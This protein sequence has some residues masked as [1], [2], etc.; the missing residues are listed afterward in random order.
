MML[1]ETDKATGDA[2]DVLAFAEYERAVI[3]HLLN[4]S[5][6]AFPDLSQL[7]PEDFTQRLTISAWIE[8]A[9]LRT[10]GHPIDYLSL[11]ER[12]VNA[13]GDRNEVETFL[14]DC[15]LKAPTAQH[16]VYHVQRIQAATRHR[17]VKTA[18]TVAQEEQGSGAKPLSDI[19]RT[20][21]DKL[22]SIEAEEVNKP[23]IISAA[24]FAAVNRTEPIQ[25]VHGV[26]RA[27][28]VGILSASSKAGKTWALLG[29][30]FAVATS[31]RWLGW[32]TAQGRVLYINAELPDYDLESRLNKL[33]D[34]LGLGGIPDG[35][36]VWHLRG[37]TMTIPQLLPAI[38]RRQRNHG[39]YA[40]IMPDPLYRFGQGRD[41]ND[42]AVQALTMGEL[43]ELAEKTA[44]AVLAAHHFSKGNQSGREHID[45]GS[46]AGMF[47]RAPDL[48][49]TLTAHKEP[50]CY[51]LESTCRSFAKPDPVVVR[52]NYPS[53]TVA[54]ELDPEE[55]KQPTGRPARYSTDELLDLLPADGL[56]HGDW[57]DKAKQETG[58]GATRFNE[59]V[60]MAKGSGQVVLACG[61]YIRGVRYDPKS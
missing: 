60:R 8:A 22:D 23:Q 16:A 20:L 24:I 1:R 43:G 7:Q 52:W 39:P 15:Q 28:Q 57:K 6:A 3:G 51:T 44:A 26:L 35:L 49:A 42:N 40:L 54:E 58:I 53:W 9:G 32:N 61:K 33:A 27:G 18:I 56:T 59:L 37:Q 10:A 47:A 17:K 50:D 55:L 2:S 38:M 13:G 41:E 45:R 36:D 29:A 4:T 19:V 34:A 31:G 11:S 30:G 5:D 14:E 46:G 21:R 25:I 48:I 12:M